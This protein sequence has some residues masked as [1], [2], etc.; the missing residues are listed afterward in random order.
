MKK[1]LIFPIVIAAGALAYLLLFMFVVH[2]PLTIDEFGSY[3]T[4]KREILA[5]TPAPRILIFAGSNGR[6]S[7]S[8]AQITADTGVACVNLSNSA[9]INLK[10]QLDNYVDLLRPGDVIYLPLEYRSG[11]YFPT[12]SATRR[13]T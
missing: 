9:S 5:T 13:S 3:A 10:Y 2:R 6:F 8:C 12:A 4:R 7:H 1:L 11:T